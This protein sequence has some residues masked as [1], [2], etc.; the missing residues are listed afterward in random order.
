ML[1]RAEAQAER[2]RDPEW[3]AAADRW[4]P[5][6][7]SFRASAERSDPAV[8]AFLLSALRPTDA[9]LDV[10]A[11][12]GRFSL[13]L[14]QAVRRVVALE[15]SPTMVASLAADLEQRGIRNVEIVESTWEEAPA[16][17]V[18]AA[19]AAHVVYHV[20]AIEEFVLK[21]DRAARRWSALVVFAEAPQAH[22]SVFWE[23]VHGEPR[24]PGPH[25]PQVL[26]VLREL[27]FAPV[28]ERAAVPLWPLGPPDRA[29]DTLRRRLYVRPDTPAD[30]RLGAAMQELLEDRGGVLAVRGATEADVGLVRWRQIAPGAL[31]A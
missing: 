24:A 14:A 29:R 26:D 2:T 6:A 1:D 12:A 9:V 3:Q 4:Q 11:G 13:P 31:Q 28:V 20:R 21:L 17:D 30:A 7:R 23:R 18:D 16:F 27:G 25:L 8:V 22:L 10:G 5:H 15:P 19:F